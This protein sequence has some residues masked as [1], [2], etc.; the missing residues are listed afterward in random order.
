LKD[1]SDAERFLKI[2]Q[3]LIITSGQ[4]SLTKGEIEQESL[5]L[6]AA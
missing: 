2:D 1:E 6:L 4:S 3:H 5:N